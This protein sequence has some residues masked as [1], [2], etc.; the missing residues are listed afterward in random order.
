MSS[1]ST[2]TAGAPELQRG[3]TFWSAFGI[4]FAI[5]S[6]IIAVYSVLGFALVDGGPGAWW[7]FVIALVG[8]LAIGL[9][10]G[11]LASRWPYEGSIYQWSRRLGG[12]TYGWFAGWA[13]M[14]TYAVASAAICYGMV[15][16]IPAALGIS[17]FGKGTKLLV[18]FGLLALATLANTTGRRWLKLLVLASITAEIIGSIGIGTVLMFFH[19]NQPVSAIVNYGGHGISGGTGL[20]GFLAALAFVGWAFNGF[21]SAGAIG[22]EVENPTRNIP[23]AILLVIVMIG[24]LALYSSLAIILAIP[25]VGAVLAGKYDDPVVSTITAALGGGISH[26]LFF[27]FIVSFFAGLVAAQTAVSRVVWAYAR[28]GVLPGSRSLIQLTG[29]DDLPVRAIF[30][31]T[32][33]IGLLLF[34]GLSDNVFATL[35][36]FTTGGFFIAFSFAVFGYL[37][38]KLTGRWQPGEFRLGASAVPVAILAAVWCVGEFINVAW[39]RG[40]LPWFESWG[41]LLMTAV[42]GAIGVVFYS[43]IRGRIETWNEEPSAHATAAVAGDLEPV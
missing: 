13:Y 39:P 11:Q 29:H 22:E 8:S 26:W 23:R 25:D 19:H 16:F 20:A 15:A 31:A 34:V 4:A 42:F 24:A 30:A 43:L 32:S 3:F 6:P 33:V 40:G 37:R 18:A 27:A 9:V 14:A 5:V 21:E 12:P 35:I 28:D 2:P 7:T 10:L 41:V 1:S 36:T 17:E 38:L